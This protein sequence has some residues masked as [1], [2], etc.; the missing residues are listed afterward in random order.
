MA[1]ER[2]CEH[3]RSQKEDYEDEHEIRRIGGMGARYAL[4]ISYSP[5]SLA[6][7]FS[8]KKFCDEKKLHSA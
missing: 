2:D 7:R 5:G 6:D 1:G 4:P 8:G 3:E